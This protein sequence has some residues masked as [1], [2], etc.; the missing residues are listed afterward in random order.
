[1][2]ND[3]VDHIE[4]HLY[5]DYTLNKMIEQFG[6]PESVRLHSS[7]ATCSSCDMWTPWN[8]SLEFDWTVFE[9]FLY[10]EQGLLFWGW[11]HSSGTGCLCP[12]MKIDNFCYGE[13]QSMGR[14]LSDNYLADLCLPP[15]VKEVPGI[16]VSE[17]HGFGGGYQLN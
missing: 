14:T 1:M 6:P 17:W 10:P 16:G 4:G 15:V 13:P 12:E 2:D 9:Y 8:P 11:I 7:Y 5:F 3:T